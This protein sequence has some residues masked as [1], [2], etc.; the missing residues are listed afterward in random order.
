MN[1]TV[2]TIVTCAGCGGNLEESPQTA[3]DQRVACPGCGSRARAFKVHATSTV[4]VTSQLS[5][6]AYESGKKKPFL[7]HKSGD[8]FFRKA[9][10]WVKRVMRI[11]RRN[12]RYVEHVV[13]PRTGDTIHFCDEPLTDHRSHDSAKSGHDV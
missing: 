1:D 4:H 2:E 5:A 13:D 8:S 12:N 6:K 10:L 11:D 7:E 9:Q 3:P